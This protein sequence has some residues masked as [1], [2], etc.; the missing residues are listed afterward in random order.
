MNAR[1]PVQTHA[2]LDKTYNSLHKAAGLKL[3]LLPERVVADY[4]E[5][6][7]QSLGLDAPGCRILEL[8]SGVGWLS[9]CL[10]HNLP[11]AAIVQCTEQAGGGAL[12]WLQANIARNAHLNLAHLRCAVLDWADFVARTSAGRIDASA[13]RYEGA[14][15]GRREAQRCAEACAAVECNQLHADAQM[16]Q[17]KGTATH[18]ARR[19]ATCAVAAAQIT[20]ANAG[21]WDVIVGSDLI[22]NDDVVKQ[23]PRVFAH[24]AQSNTRI[25]YAHTKHRFEHFDLEFFDELERA[26]LQWQEVREAW[27]PA[28]PDSPPPFESLFPDMRIAVYLI[29]K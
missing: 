25:V 28:P 4:L 5:A 10:A 21:C 9:M 12:Q 7:A 6:E 2:S 17:V 23:L 3:L 15:C 20:P 24:L 22:Y 13:T 29:T 18:S 19:P 1:I 16:A 14:A 27:A 26:G 8:G 11:H